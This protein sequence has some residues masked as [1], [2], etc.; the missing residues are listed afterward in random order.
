MGLDAAAE[1]WM[2]LIGGEGN[3][4]DRPLAVVDRDREAAAD[5]E[6][7]GLVEKPLLRRRQLVQINAVAPLERLRG[8]RG[9]ENDR[10][11]AL[12][13]AFDVMAGPGCRKGRAHL[14]VRP[15]PA[16][17]GRLGETAQVAG[18][19]SEEHTAELQS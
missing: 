8:T 17:H 19:R 10:A 15:A 6:S 2:A 5:A 12:V 16:G 4:R 9:P 14:C 1:R 13:V 3:G 11:D 7:G 18:G